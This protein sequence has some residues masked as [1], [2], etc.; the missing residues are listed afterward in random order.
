MPELTLPKRMAG[1]R[2]IL[3]RQGLLIVGGSGDNSQGNW[4]SRL[5]QILQLT[6][7]GDKIESCSWTTMAT[8]LKFGGYSVV[9]P[10][11]DTFEC[12]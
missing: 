4:E 9:I 6:C 10:V 11:P 5:D 2:M 7:T 8:K 3:T 1:F 12:N